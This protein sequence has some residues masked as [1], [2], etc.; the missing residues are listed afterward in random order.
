MSCLPAHGWWWESGMV[1][2]EGPPAHPQHPSLPCPHRGRVPPPEASVSPAEDPSQWGA[3]LR[4][5]GCQEWQSKSAQPEPSLSDPDSTR[6][7]LPAANK[8]HAWPHVSPSSVCP[9]HLLGGR[10][11]TGLASGSTPAGL[12]APGD[13]QSHLVM[14]V[15]GGRARSWELGLWAG[16][17]L[18][19]RLLVWPLAEVF[20]GS[21][22]GTGTELARRTWGV[23]V[24]RLHWPWLAQGA[25][26]GQRVTG[27]S[28]GSLGFCIY[29]YIWLHWA[30]VAACRILVP[31]VGIKPRPLH[32][33][34]KV[35]NTG[36][37]RSPWQPALEPPVKCVHSTPDEGLLIHFSSDKPTQR[38]IHWQSSG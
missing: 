19:T 29:I 17:H 12:E 9:W 4:A 24:T 15:C 6:C 28:P 37:Q 31:W 7:L 14:S 5:P 1:G 21:G 33:E 32:W 3:A 13:R 10:K 23:E 34:H 8:T 36:L 26:G 27:H 30:L 11:H 38:G 22:W 2:V 18:S 16:R 20:L 25:H 35:L